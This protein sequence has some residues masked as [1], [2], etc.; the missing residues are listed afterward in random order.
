[1]GDLVKEIR[2][3]NPRTGKRDGNYCTWEGAGKCL[4]CQAADYIE[5]LEAQLDAVAEKDN[6]I[7]NPNIDSSLSIDETCKWQHDLISTDSYT[8]Y[9]SWATSCG[10]TFAILEEWHEKPTKFCS[11]CGKKVEALEEVK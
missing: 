4:K 8:E 2:C 10:E 3:F 1:M 9:D 6:P 11:N 7:K 5:E